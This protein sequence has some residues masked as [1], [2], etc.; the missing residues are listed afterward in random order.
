MKYLAVICASA[1]LAFCF[2]LHAIIRPAMGLT[3]TATDS[4]LKFEMII[5]EYSGDLFPGTFILSEGGKQVTSE[6]KQY[7]NY[8]RRITMAV[9]TG[10]KGDNDDVGYIIDLTKSYNGS[11]YGDATQYIANPPGTRD[12]QDNT[13]T[14]LDCQVRRP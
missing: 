7:S 6:V 12:E 10:P 1:V 9:S 11:Y 13:Y 5:N 3:C 8:K 14:R 2:Q 4:D